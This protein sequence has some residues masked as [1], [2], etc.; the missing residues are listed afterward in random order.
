M[1][2]RTITSFIREGDKGRKKLKNGLCYYQEQE[3][4]D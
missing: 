1:G 4:H 2:F 3:T